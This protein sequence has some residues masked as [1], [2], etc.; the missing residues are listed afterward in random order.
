MLFF[1]QQANKKNQI[2][3]NNISIAMARVFFPNNT[4]PK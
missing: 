1:W 3:T 4:L 2:N